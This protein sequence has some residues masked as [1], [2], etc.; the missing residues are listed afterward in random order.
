MTVGNIQ[1]DRQTLEW[2][3]R[4]KRIKHLVGRTSFDWAINV[5]YHYTGQGGFTGAGLGV[6]DHWIGYN[7]NLFGRE[8]VVFTVLNESGGWNPCLDKPPSCMFGQEPRD[9][10]LDKKGNLVGIWDIEHLREL[11]RSGNRVTSYDL[12]DL[13]KSV[14]RYLFKTS[15]ET[16][17]LFDL[18]VDGT[19]KHTSGISNDLIGHVIRQTAAFCRLLQLECPK[20]AVFLRLRNEWNAHDDISLA[21]VNMWA[22]RLYRWKRIL[23]SGDWTSR[24]PSGGPMVSFTQPPTPSDGGSEWF[25]EQMPNCFGIIDGGGG[26]TSW[27]VDIGQEPGKYQ[28]LAFHQDRHRGRPGDT[29]IDPITNAEL[30]QMNSEAHGQPRMNTENMY[31]LSMPGT[32]HWYRNPD[33][34]NNDIDKQLR[35]YDNNVKLVNEF[36]VH[37]DWGKKAWVGWNQTP[38]G[39]KWEDGLREFFNPGAQPPPPSPPTPGNPL[40][41][42]IHYLAKGRWNAAI[43]PKGLFPVTLKGG[44]ED[45]A[46]ITLEEGGGIADNMGVL[47]GRWKVDFARAETI[48]LLSAFLGVDRGDV[49]ELSLSVY[50]RGGNDVGM[51]LCPTISWHKEA[52][53][54]AYDAYFSHDVN[55][56][57]CMGLDIHFDARVLLGSQGVSHPD[58]RG[59][60]TARPHLGV[61]WWNLR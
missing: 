52:Q 11:S 1:W 38:K 27:G 41:G 26:N 17:C 49:V 21:E 60:L 20:A 47:R 54:A 30:N 18:V 43:F 36:T 14:L 2:L 22:E 7:Q 25:A 13:N 48:V 45:D 34:W 29:W 53:F 55:H 42:N 23:P 19:L 4:G 58:H 39:K 32:A 8:E 31:F 6:A 24:N 40:K 33:G 16:G 56:V 50:A 59:E 10:R 44:S 12:T 28:A 61:E 51:K 15:H 35:F 3:I 5:S 57:N 46:I 37:D 9:Q